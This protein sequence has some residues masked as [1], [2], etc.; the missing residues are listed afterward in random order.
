FPDHQDTTK[1]MS[2]VQGITYQ[3]IDPITG[4]QTQA[5]ATSSSTVDETT[6]PGRGTVSGAPFVIYTPNVCHDIFRTDSFEFVA[7]DSSGNVSPP[8]TISMYRA[9]ITCPH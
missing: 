5:M 6:G 3:F 9:D 7:I 2:M 8:A 1:T 4:A